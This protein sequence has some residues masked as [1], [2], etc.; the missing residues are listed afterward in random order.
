M[1][2]TD[3]ANTGSANVPSAGLADRPLYRYILNGELGRRKA[4][5]AQ[6]S[7]RA[8]AR[9]LGVDPADLS[10]A[11]AGKKPISL[12]VG[13]KAVEKLQ[14]TP[15]EQGLFLESIGDEQ[16]RARLKNFGAAE[17]DPPP[18]S[19]IDIDTFTVISE[20]YYAA[21]LELINL[22]HFVPDIAWIASQL[23]LS[24]D[25]VEDALVRLV[26]L[27]LLK[28][29]N[30]TFQRTGKILT[31]KDKHLSTPALRRFQTQVLKGAMSS[32]ACDP[33]ELRSQSSM[34]MAIDP[35]K[36][37]IAKQ[38]I[39]DFANYLCCFLESGKRQQVYQLSLSLYPLQ[40]SPPKGE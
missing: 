32:L 19:V 8:F 6:Y 31:T 40:V 27:E 21:L 28:I 35:S 33:I 5:N 34:T 17:G 2:E 15:N 20:M 1:L 4:K 25:V 11:L 29:E 12:K 37:P 10:K 38:M 18:A 23:Q 24:E 39:E 14:L 9:D 22:E 16:K 26:R 7:L 13:L 30:G 3:V 36:L